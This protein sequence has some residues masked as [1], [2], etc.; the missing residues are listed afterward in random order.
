MELTKDDKVVVVILSYK[1]Y[2]NSEKYEILYE[3]AR[4]K[5]TFKNGNVIVNL[6]QYRRNDKGELFLYAL[7]RY[8]TRIDSNTIFDTI[9]EAKLGGKKMLIKLLEG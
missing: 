1:E 4:V 8:N 9:E 6:H 3:K 2:N 7:S 5:K